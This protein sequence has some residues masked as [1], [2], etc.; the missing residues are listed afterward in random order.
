MP[1]RLWTRAP[2]RLNKARVSPPS[3]A[4]SGPASL[5]PAFAGA[6]ATFSGIGLARFAYVPLFPAMVNAG[7]VSGG[8]AGLLGALNLAGYLT[9]VLGGRGLA[10]RLGTRAALHLGM[11][12]AALSCAGCAVDLGL[13]WLAGWRAAAGAAGGVL[14]A[15]AG[16]AVQGAVAP[17]RRGTAGGIVMT[18]VGAGIVTASLASPVLLG[19]GLAPAWLALALAVAAAWAAAARSFPATPVRPVAAAAPRGAGALYLA[20][21]LSAA[22]LVPHMVYFGDLVVRGRGFD[23][24]YGSLTWLA[25]GIGGLLGPLLGGRAADRWG[26]LAAIRLWLALQAAALA[27]ALLPGLPALAAAAFLGGFAT[28]GLTSVALARTRE[29]A[30]AGSG[31][32]WVR[33]TAAFAVAQATTSFGYA[34]LFAGTGSHDPLFAVGLA[35]SLAALVP[36]VLPGSAGPR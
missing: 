13:P 4:P 2:F 27:L 33:A 3:P 14:M 31:A 15:L 1:R 12:L 19:F 5:A 11:A 22:G 10:R 9:G 36:V 25:F 8:E 18:G 6:A 26:S 23:P 28:I 21:G 30:G 17:A 32:I 16:P 24:A 20:Y 7:W 35:L 34:A 29:I